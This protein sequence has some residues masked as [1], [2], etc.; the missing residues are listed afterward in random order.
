[1]PAK[2][3]V[4]RKNNRRKRKSEKVSAKRYLCIPIIIVLTGKTNAVRFT[5]RFVYR[6]SSATKFERH[7]PHIVLGSLPVECLGEK[8][9]GGTLSWG[10]RLKI[11][12]SLCV[13]VC[14]DWLR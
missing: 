5:P 10:K 12:T 3:D 13:C 2:T 9:E 7:F 11:F 8:R 6:N 1:M 4:R 14:N